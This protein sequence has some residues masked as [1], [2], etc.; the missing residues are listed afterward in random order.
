MTTIPPRTASFQAYTEVGT[1]KVDDDVAKFLDADK[2]E[3]IRFLYLD[4]HKHVFA[5]YNGEV[6]VNVYDNNRQALVIIS[7]GHYDYQAPKDSE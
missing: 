2:L 6:V 7:E 3:S 4:A 1:T 5:L